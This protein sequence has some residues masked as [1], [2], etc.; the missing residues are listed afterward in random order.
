VLDLPAILDTIHRQ[1]ADGPQWLALAA[2]LR[3]NGRDDEADAGRVFWPV[4]R[5]NFEAGVSVE[6]TLRQLE[7]NAATLAR[8]AR[9]VSA[10]LPSQFR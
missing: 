7:R 5:D 10:R 1:P 3:D 9:R 4:L 6:A 2:W 8:H